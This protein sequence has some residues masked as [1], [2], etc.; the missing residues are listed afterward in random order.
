[1]ASPLML[2]WIP[3][4]PLRGGGLNDIVVI[5]LNISKTGAKAKKE[6]RLIVRGKINAK[7]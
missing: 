5:N 1:M 6:Q 2:I 3:R 4:R 7:N